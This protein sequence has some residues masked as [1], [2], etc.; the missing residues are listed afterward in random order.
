MTDLDRLLGAA[1]LTVLVKSRQRCALRSKVVRR[2]ATG[3]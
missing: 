1:I 3:L 2:R